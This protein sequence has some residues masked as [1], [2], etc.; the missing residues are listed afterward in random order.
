MVL[1][2]L[3][4]PV[5][6]A[7]GDCVSAADRIRVSPVNHLGEQPDLSRCASAPLEVGSATAAYCLDWNAIVTMDGTVQVVSLHARGDS[8]VVEAYDGALPRMLT[9]GDSIDD[10]RGKLG[11]PNRITGVY[12]TPTFVYMY[13]GM[14]YGSLELRFNGDGGLTAINACLQR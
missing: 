5:G 1:F 7:I 13:R 12:G 6:G 4:G 14:P 9:W 8:S 10:V 3:L 11:P 2:L